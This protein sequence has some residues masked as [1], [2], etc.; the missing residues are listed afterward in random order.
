MGDEE[1]RTRP[2]Q[3]STT[4]EAKPNKVV[5]FLN[6]VKANKVDVA[7]WTTRLLSIMFTI[8]YVLG[9]QYPS[10]F[11][12]VLL[13]NAATSALRLHQRLLNYSFSRDFLAR[14][15]SEDS[16]H[17]L[18]FT[19]IFLSAQP[20]LLILVPI[21]LFAV[22][23]ASS[24]ALK[25]LDLLRI[26]TLDIVIRFF[27]AIVEF[28]AENILRAA[29]FSEIFLMP[30]TLIWTLMGRTG[31]MTPI[32]FYHFLSMRY[33]SRRNPYTRLAFEFLR[34]VADNVALKSPPFVKY[35]IAQAISMISRLA[36]QPQPVPPQMPQ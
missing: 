11:S 12:K 19:V 27:I 23:H 33:S 6:H 24:Y 7:L 2:T 8:F 29:A 16:C 34:V 28:Q 36:P 32:L 3:G 1:P 26:N 30:M 25:L 22:L 10:A 21:V 15:L 14:L 9:I 20:T 17:Y 4:E 18:L 5:L 13:A 35:V 31:I